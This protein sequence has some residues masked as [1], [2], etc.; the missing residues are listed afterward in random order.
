MTIAFDK[1]RTGV[2]WFCLLLL[3]V[4]HKTMAQQKDISEFNTNGG[5]CLFS[6][7]DVFLNGETW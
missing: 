4:P 5:N 2:A 3:A 7:V 1:P 6:Q